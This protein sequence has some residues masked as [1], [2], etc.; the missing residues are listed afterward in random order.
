M[1]IHIGN[2]E[3][4]MMSDCVGIFNFATLSQDNQKMIQTLFN[5]EKI[6]KFH[7]A[8]LTRDGKYTLSSLSSEALAGRGEGKLF[9]DTF[10]RR[11]KKKP[12]EKVQEK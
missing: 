8:I 3:F 5:K 2:N 7:S 10:Y 9:P 6:E 4:V 11:K 1:I 12:P